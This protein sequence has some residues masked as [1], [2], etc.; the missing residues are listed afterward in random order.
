VI[1]FAGCVSAYDLGL[2]YRL[3][4]WGGV[5][6]VLLAG[7]GPFVSSSLGRTAKLIHTVFYFYLVN[8][9]AL[10]GVTKAVG[11]RVDR[12]WAPERG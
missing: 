7:I 10:L 8:V 11:G 1:G 4:A 5:T 6:S 2:V 9:A 12:I 3:G